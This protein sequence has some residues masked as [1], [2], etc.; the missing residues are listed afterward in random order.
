MPNMIWLG[1]AVSLSARPDALASPASPAHCFWGPA[2]SG[3]WF[4][5]LA[6]STPTLNPSPP[7][8]PLVSS[9][10]AVVQGVGVGA[11][12]RGQVEATERNQRKSQGRAEESKGKEVERKDTHGK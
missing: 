10:N 11:G 1:S 3:V 2:A 12:G 9:K 7:S 5:W 4:L 6:G 8:D